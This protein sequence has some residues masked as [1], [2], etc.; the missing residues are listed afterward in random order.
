MTRA[1]RGNEA[2]AKK[3]RPAWEY[4]TTGN[5]IAWGERHIA[6]RCFTGRFWP[7]DEDWHAGAL[8]RDGYEAVPLG[9]VV[10]ARREPVKPQH[11]PKCRFHIAAT[12]AGA[13]EC[14]HGF[15]VCPKCDPCTCVPLPPAD[16][17]TGDQ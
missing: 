3:E 4:G 10:P 16:G 17:D 12:C 13:V 7:N 15:D 14:E 11:D 1:A 9:V 5:V 6:S 8:K 2:R